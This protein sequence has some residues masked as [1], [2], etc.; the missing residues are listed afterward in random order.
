[1]LLKI[2]IRTYDSQQHILINQFTIDNHDNVF[3]Q[4]WIVES[5]L[6]LGG[7]ASVMES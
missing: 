2:H 5:D 6:Y 4:Y 3:I 7:I 1:M